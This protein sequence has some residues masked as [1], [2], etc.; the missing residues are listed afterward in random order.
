[1]FAQQLL[2]LVDRLI[3]MTQEELVLLKKMKIKEAGVI[4]TEKEPLVTLY[5]NCIDKI[6]V[7]KAMASLLKKWEKFELLK[8]RI[9][10]L[11][12]LSVEHEL[13]IKRFE[14]AQSRFVRMM[15]ET[16]LDVVQPVQNYNNRGYVV[17]RQQHYAKQGGG[18]LAALD[19]AL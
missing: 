19:Q 3:E 13:Y 8:E 10:F 11:G 4:T 12:D 18:S 6:K 1:M 15:Q 17:N 9:A 2:K 14:K 5:Q 16:V 7:D